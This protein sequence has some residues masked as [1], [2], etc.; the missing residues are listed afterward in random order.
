MRI[1]EGREGKVA[2]HLQQLGAKALPDRGDQ[3]RLYRSS[4]VIAARSRGEPRKPDLQKLS[5]P[6]SLSL[7]VSESLAPGGESAAH[8]WP[9]LPCAKRCGSSARPSGGYERPQAGNQTE[10]LNNPLP[11]LTPCLPG[12]SSRLLLSSALN[13]V[14]SSPWHC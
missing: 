5:L 11:S 13:Q 1:Q 3:L 9:S 7:S 2:Q 14:P 4:T 8:D 10:L 6:I 12:S